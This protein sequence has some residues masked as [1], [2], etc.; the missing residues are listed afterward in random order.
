MFHIL[1]VTCLSFFLPQNL[2]C[3]LHLYFVCT[4]N[5]LIS[6]F[7]SFISN[8]AG[9]TIGSKYKF[10]TIELYRI[11]TIIWLDWTQKS[12]GHE[13]VNSLLMNWSPKAIVASYPTTLSTLIWQHCTLFAL[14]LVGNYNL[15]IML[16]EGKYQLKCNMR[17]WS[18][19]ISHNSWMNEW[20]DR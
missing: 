4:T 18:S 13:R 12:I 6:H 9:K 15:F 20:I 5:L 19:S 14:K 11:N 8:N 1:F 7:F 3:S 16:W 17:V 2:S 10:M